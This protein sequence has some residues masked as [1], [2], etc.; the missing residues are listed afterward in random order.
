MYNIYCAAAYMDVYKWNHNE[1][2]MLG[3]CLFNTCTLSEQH[4]IIIMFVH[5]R[6]VCGAYLW[7]VCVYAVC[8]VLLETL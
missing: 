2:G 4:Y 7:L 5:Q 1:T 8:S 3:K 6:F